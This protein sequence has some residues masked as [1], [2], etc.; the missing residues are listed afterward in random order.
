MSDSINSFHIWNFSL[1]ISK[2]EHSAV[3]TFGCLLQ[4][5]VAIHR[6]HY[7]SHRW[8]STETKT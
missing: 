3:A 6:Y 2:I 1:L 4:I 7:P 8:K 5:H